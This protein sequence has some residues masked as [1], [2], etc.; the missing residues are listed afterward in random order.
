M[1]LNNKGFTIAELLVSF[2]LITIILASLISSTIYF[3]DRLKQEE[4]ISQLKDFK[5]NVTKVL[6]DD[7]IRGEIVSVNRCIGTA[8]CLNLVDTN[9]SSRVLKIE[10]PNTA[11]DK[12]VYL[13]YRG[14]KYFLPDSDLGG[15]SNRV[16][17][18][19]GGF[20]LIDSGTY[21]LYKIKTS[22]KHK[23][24]DLQYDLLIVVN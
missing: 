23:D 5:N 4:V 16:C 8:N 14:I 12:G 17:D 7:I 22:F 15:A 1:K 6:Q 20:E 18:F 10:E 11:T 2:S 3:R 9:G 24:F 19:I 13:S 21:P